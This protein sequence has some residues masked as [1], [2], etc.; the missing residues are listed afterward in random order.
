VF[1]EEKGAAEA[2]PRETVSKLAPDGFRA[3]AIFVP[4][5]RSLI[6]SD[7]R[8]TFHRGNNSSAGRRPGC[9]AVYGCGACPNRH[10]G[11]GLYEHGHPDRL[12]GATDP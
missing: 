6:L 10:E 11:R 1:D 12:A 8:C 2:T 7:L 5:A 9:A 4:F 3:R